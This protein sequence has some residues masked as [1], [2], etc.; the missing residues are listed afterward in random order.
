M[1]LLYTEVLPPAAASC[2]AITSLLQAGLELRDPH[3]RRLG[4]VVGEVLLELGLELG[5]GLCLDVDEGLHAL[6]GDLEDGGVGRIV[7]QRGVHLP[8]DQAA[9]RLPALDG[10]GDVLGRVVLDVEVGARGVGNVEDY[11]SHF[12][13]ISFVFG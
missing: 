12:F 4:R 8:V 13:L 7:A 11:G 2:S 10:E 1:V 6:K 9:Q 5:G 3:G